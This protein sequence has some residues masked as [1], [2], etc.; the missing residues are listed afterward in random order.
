MIETKLYTQ[1]YMHT[2][3]TMQDERVQFISNNFC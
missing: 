1:A 2:Y 3:P